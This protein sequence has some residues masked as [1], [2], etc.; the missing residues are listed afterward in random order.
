MSSDKETVL[1]RLRACSVFGWQAFVDALFGDGGIHSA[2]DAQRRL[3]ELLEGDPLPEEDCEALRWVREHGGLEAL[4]RDFQDADSRRVELCAS[5]GIDLE[6][7]WSD[8][9]AAMRPRL[10]PEGYEWPRYEDGEP[11][12]LSEYDQRP[13]TISC[14]AFNFHE[15]VIDHRQPFVEINTTLV[16][17]SKTVML[18]MGEHVKRLAPKVLDADG[19]EICVG[20]TVWTLR[21]AR[22]LEVIGLY[23]EHSYPVKVKERKNGAYTFSGIEPTDL[24]HRAPVLAADGEPLREGE[25]VWSVDSGTRYTVEK[26]TDELI[27]IKCRIEMGSTVSL[28]PSQLTHE[29]PESWERLEEDCAKSDVDYCAER[30]LLDPSCDTV[31]G[32]ASTRHCTDCGCTCGEKMARDLVRRAR[33]LAERG[34]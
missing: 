19:E 28:C 25:T 1:A 17:N 26:I 18:D 4:R 9:M 8:A 21:D 31:E 11:V 30:G 27:P 2:M 5:L 6:T 14:V 15:A 12:I 34:Q 33:A 24:T 3:I 10:M 23:P 32:D 20:D 22:E 29:R 16:P 7:G 13:E